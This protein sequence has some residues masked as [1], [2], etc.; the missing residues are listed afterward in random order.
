MLS[1]SS[2]V[3]Q[4]APKLT[5]ATAPKMCVLKSAI[6]SILA[7]A[8]VLVTFKTNAY[9]DITLFGDPAV[10]LLRMM[11]QSGNV[12]GAIMAEDVPAALASLRDELAASAAAAEQGSQESP[13]PAAEDDEADANPPVA[14]HKRAGPLIELLEAAIT[15]SDNVLW[16]Q[17]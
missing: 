5:T 10:S 12:P 15:A 6:H 7:E 9:S 1:D 4:V 16:S 8:H 14:L 3:Q 11:G 17:Y 2:L 13:E